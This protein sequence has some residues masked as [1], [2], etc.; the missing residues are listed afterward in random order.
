MPKAGRHDSEAVIFEF[1]DGSLLS[2]DAVTN[3]G[4]LM[5]EEMAI[6]TGSA[7]RHLDVTYV[8]PL[9]PFGAERGKADS[10][11]WASLISAWVIWMRNY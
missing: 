4:Q 10:R 1:S 7:A 11:N 2:I 9:E 6:R 5:R 3:I 8:P